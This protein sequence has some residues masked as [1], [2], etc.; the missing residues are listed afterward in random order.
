MQDARLYYLGTE[1]GKRIDKL[2]SKIRERLIDSC[3]TH[4]I[5]QA[6]IN[7]DEN[8]SKDIE[9]CF[10]DARSSEFYQLILAVMYEKINEKAYNAALEIGEYEY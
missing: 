9:F 7:L 3:T 2:Q 4:D 5:G 1:K 6:L 8:Y 10:H